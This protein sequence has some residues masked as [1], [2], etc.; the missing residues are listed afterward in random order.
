MIKNLS[1]SKF[2]QFSVAEGERNEAQV[3]NK[4]FKTRTPLV[5]NGVWLLTE[6]HQQQ[7]QQIAT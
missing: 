5:N 2:P 1:P 4:L 3:S 6:K 7:R